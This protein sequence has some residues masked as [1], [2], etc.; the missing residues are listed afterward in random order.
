M[1]LTEAADTQ[2]M[3][4]Y[5]HTAEDKYGNP[6][7]KAHWQ[8]LKDHLRRVAGLAKEYRLGLGLRTDATLAGLLH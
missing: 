8:L 1:I 3:T 4:S 7:P 2:I 6:L 5:A